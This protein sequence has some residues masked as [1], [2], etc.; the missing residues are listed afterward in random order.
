MV[1]FNLINFYFFFWENFNLWHQLMMIVLYHQTKT[2]I[3]FWCRRKLNPRSLIQL[4]EI[5]LVELTGTHISLI[6]WV[7]CLVRVLWAWLWCWICWVAE[8]FLQIWFF[9]FFSSCILKFF[10]PILVW[11]VVFLIQWLCFSLKRIW[12]F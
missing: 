11:V 6:S 10:E 12:E 5:L 3:G 9:F 4:S 2:P 8:I 7:Y 1:L